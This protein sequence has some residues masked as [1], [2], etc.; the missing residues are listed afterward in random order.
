MARSVVPLRLSER[1]KAQIER[2]AKT[3]RITLSE[4][5]RR[6]ALAVSARL[7]AATKPET[8]EAEP[9]DST[10]V[11]SSKLSAEPRLNRQE[12]EALLGRPLASGCT[13]EQYGTLAGRGAA[14]GLGPGIRSDLIGGER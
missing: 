6:A 13:W 4:F 1:E 12:Q 2:A 14:G 3:Q 8:P 11:E 5:L 9:D 10:I 7:E